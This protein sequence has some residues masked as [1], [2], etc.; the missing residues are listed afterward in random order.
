ME[1]T[2][3]T[4]LLPSASQLEMIDVAMTGNMSAAMKAF[5]TGRIKIKGAM[6]RGAALMP[7]FS[8]MGKLTRK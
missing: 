7:L 4:L 8:A 3:L 6:M 1:D 5:I 2:D